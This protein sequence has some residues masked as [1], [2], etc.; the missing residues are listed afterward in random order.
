MIILSITPQAYGS[1]GVFEQAIHK[2]VHR[3]WVDSFYP[4]MRL[5]ALRYLLATSA[6]VN[7]GMSF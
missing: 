2:V 5:N 7:D 1:E 6:A 4:G 3:F